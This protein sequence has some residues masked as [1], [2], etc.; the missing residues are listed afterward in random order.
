[1]ADLSIE[2][3]TGLVREKLTAGSG[4]NG[5]VKVVFDEGGQILISGRPAPGTVT[6]EDGPADLTLRLSLATLNKLHRRELNATS[7][8]MS[9]KIKIEGNLMLAMQLD[10][11]LS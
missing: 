3:L 5:T 10:K 7:A 6:S 9:G 4:L 2:E 1:M 8:V 11:I